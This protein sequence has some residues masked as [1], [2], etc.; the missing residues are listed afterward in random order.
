[1]HVLRTCCAGWRGRRF[2]VALTGEDATRNRASLCE[3]SVVV[4][5]AQR[6]ISGDG[7]IPLS[8]AHMGTSRLVCALRRNAFGVVGHVAEGVRID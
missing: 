6:R 5:V 3:D 2:E 7:A 8:C 1:M 4:A